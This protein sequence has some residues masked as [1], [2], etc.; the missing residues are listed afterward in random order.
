M[1]LPVAG[2][3]GSV[4]AGI[5]GGGGKGK[6]GGGKQQSL[7]LIYMDATSVHNISK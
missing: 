7:F 1:C 3:F 4:G 2:Q 5:P 6:G